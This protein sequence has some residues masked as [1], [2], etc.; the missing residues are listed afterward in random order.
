MAKTRIRLVTRGDDSGSCNTANVAIWN[1]YKKGILRNTSIMVPAPAF[2]EAAEMFS[3]DRGLCVGLHVTLNAEWDSV[4]WGPVLGADKVPSIVDPNGHLFQTTQALNDNHPKLEEMVAEVRAQ[5]DMARA[6]GLEIGYMDT[7]MGVSWVGGL[8]EPLE[9]MAE[10][11]GLVY[12][13]IAAAHL[14]RLE[15]DLANPVDALLARLDAAKPGTYIVVG[16]PCYDRVDVRMFDHAGLTESQGVARD[17]Q[18]RIFRDGK[19]LDYCRETG[20]V[21]IRYTEI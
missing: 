18:R 6:C 20:V 14:P 1:A 13:H 21:P 10:R 12:S 16:H 11:E 15:G 2:P 7:H 3:E 5:L 17:W 4:R 8:K 19:V 9:Q